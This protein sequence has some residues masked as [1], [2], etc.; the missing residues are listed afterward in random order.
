MNYYHNTKNA[1]SYVAMCEGYDAAGQLGALF[2]VL[3]ENSRVLELGSGPGNDMALLETRYQVTG[4][5]YSPAFID[6]L[7]SR[8]PS[9]S[10]LELDAV[11]IAT[12]ELFDAIYSNKVLHHLN[13][14]ELRS[15]FQRQAE[16][17]AAGGCVC[18]LIWHRIVDPEID[19]GLIFKARN[20]DE[21]VALMGGAFELV[22]VEEFCEFEKGDS[23][24]ILARKI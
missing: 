19:E 21:F 11:S 2:E 22:S 23:L 5:D 7:K 17:L 12:E 1:A 14:A 24:A 13:D 16:L 18:H 20:A 8:F 4:S 3:P 9:H 10:I 15:S 6:I